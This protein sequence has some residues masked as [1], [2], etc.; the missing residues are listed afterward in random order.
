MS[1]VHVQTK[2]IGCF[3]V[4]SGAPV[5]TCPPR[6]ALIGESLSPQSS[7]D[8]HATPGVLGQV[9]RRHSKPGVEVLDQLREIRVRISPNIPTHPPANII[10]RVAE[11]DDS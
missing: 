4:A 11:S 10:A 8:A 9:I 3:V 7:K 1:G 5:A 6:Q 2:P